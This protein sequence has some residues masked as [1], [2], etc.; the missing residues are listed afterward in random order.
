VS[1]R[2]THLGSL[3][4]LRPFGACSTDE[5][6]AVGR[7][8]TTVT[9]SAGSILARQGAPSREVFVLAS[10]VALVACDGR[11][12]GVLRAGDCFGDADLLARG[13][14]S[15]T[16]VALS[17]VELVVMSHAEF[18]ALLDK[19]PSFRRRI[20]TSLAERARRREFVER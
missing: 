20:F 18:S 17:D 13:V 19:V 15:A 4:D 14:A 8:C 1:R 6:R 10:G 9:R 3:R 2:D 12:D 7:R 5:L 11:P 16:L